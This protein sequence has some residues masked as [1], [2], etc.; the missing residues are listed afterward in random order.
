MAAHTPSRP[1]HVLTAVALSHPE[2]RTV[3]DAE[4]A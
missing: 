1:F 2:E 4:E 3:L